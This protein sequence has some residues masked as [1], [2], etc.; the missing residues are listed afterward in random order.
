MTMICNNCNR[1]GIHWVGPYGNLTGTKCPH[2]SGTNCQRDVQP[3]AA[4]EEEVDEEVECGCER[5]SGPPN[6]DDGRYYCGS[7]WCM[8]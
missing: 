5:K 3:E 2:C 1:L 4:D 8:P 6:F 7:Q